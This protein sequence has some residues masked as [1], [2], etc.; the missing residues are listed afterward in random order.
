MLEKPL[1]N[2]CKSKNNEI[3]YKNFTTWITKGE[4]TLVKCKK[5]KLVYLSPRPLS[6][7]IINFYPAENYWCFNVNDNNKNTELARRSDYNFLYKKLIP[8]NK[9][10]KILDLG[11]GTG[12]FLSKFKELG[13]SVFGV[14]LSKNACKYSKKKYGIKLING[15]F[16]EVKIP[17]KKFDIVSL[18]G[19]LEHLYKPKEGLKKIYSLLN[20]D[21]V[22]EITIPNFDSLGR[23]L[24]QDKWYALQPPTHL[25]HFTPQTITNFLKISG[26]KDIKIYHNYWT[27]NIYVIFESFRLKYSPKFKDGK[28]GNFSNINNSKRS[29]FN[30]YF[31]FKK[32]LVRILTYF[33]AGLEV[34]LK[35]GEIITIY[36]KKY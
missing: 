21:G 29:T 23:T 20:V 9:K 1:C 33:L 22:I 24:F 18:N 27:Q 25:Y 5:C 31:E 11:A 30:L 2:Y 13:W 35:K 3:I 6:K 34:I 7:D 36:A 16:P 15:S 26:F 32:Y 19:C 4:Y 14:E 8:N 10:C 12:L 17:N 28:E